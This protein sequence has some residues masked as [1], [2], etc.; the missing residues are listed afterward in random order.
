MSSDVSDRV[1]NEGSSSEPQTDS[2]QGDPPTIREGPV[3]DV[4]TDVVAAD[5]GSPSTVEPAPPPELQSSLRGAPPMPSATDAQTTASV[6][7]TPPVSPGAG[8]P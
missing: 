8:Q 6:L 3:T 1:L 5:A 4:P 2:L 7:L